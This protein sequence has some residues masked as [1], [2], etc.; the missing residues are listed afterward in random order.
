MRKNTLK[1]V[2]FALAGVYVVATFSFNLGEMILA[3]FQVLGF[4][5]VG[6]L[7]ALDNYYYVT[8]EKVAILREKQSDLARFLIE[9]T[10]REE[11]TEKFVPKKEEEPKETVIELTQE[12]ADALLGSQTKMEKTE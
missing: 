11:F 9:N 3:I 8:V 10:S 12:Q 1:S 6:I 4:V 2:A 7:D 5:V